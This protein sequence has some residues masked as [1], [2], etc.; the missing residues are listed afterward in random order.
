MT[1]SPLLIIHIVAGTLAVASGGVALFAPKG[2]RTHRAAGTIFF[3]SMLIAS[4]VGAC[5]AFT[6]PA[7]FIAFLG[8]VL[9]FY[10]VL[11]GWLTVRR[12]EAR[13]GVVELA[14][15]L[16]ITTAGVFLVL[17]GLEALNSATGLKNGYA[18]DAYFFLA[19]V[20]L[21]AAALDASVL[22]R[23]SLAGRQRIARHLWRVCFGFFIAAGSLFTGPGSTVFPDAIRKSGIL[24]GPELIILL[25]M[26]FWLAR[27]LF[28]RRFGPRA[29][30]A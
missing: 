17:F 19:G 3:A 28:T 14:A 27:A 23:R 2:G 8:G 1:A 26:V 18:A 25:L 9:A 22:V 16:L 30:V 4:A 11:T 5:V 13:I 12:P 29:K 7:Q 10:L 20:A 24:S 15:G 21:L 6:I